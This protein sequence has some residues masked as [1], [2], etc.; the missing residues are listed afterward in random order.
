MQAPDDSPEPIIATATTSATSVGVDFDFDQL[1]VSG[2]GAD[3]D[4]FGIWQPEVTA[5]ARSEPHPPLE[6]EHVFELKAHELLGT[7][8]A[9]RSTLGKASDGGDIGIEL[10][11][12]DIG[13]TGFVT[14]ETS[15]LAGSCRVK[16]AT[17]P[18]GVQP[19]VVGTPLR[20]RANLKRFLELVSMIQVS[21]IEF[22]LRL[23][24]MR[25]TIVI[26]GR[27]MPVPV[28]PP[29]P[30]T[31]GGEG[32]EP[33]R[34]VDGN[35]LSALVSYL[36]IFAERDDIE[37]KFNVV[38]VGSEQSVTGSRGAI[39]RVTCRSSD[40]IPAFSLTP[41]SLEVLC[42]LVPEFQSS[43]VAYSSSASSHGFATDRLWVCIPK[44]SASFP[45]P[46]DT[47][48]TNRTGTMLVPRPSLI[49]AVDRLRGG[50]AGG[51]KIRLPSLAS[52][53]KV[54]HL[55]VMT[56]D[57]DEWTDAVAGAHRNEDL[58]S[59]NGWEG[60][61]DIERLLTILKHFDSANVELSYSG[62]ALIL[63]DESASGILRM[64]SIFGR[65]AADTPAADTKF[66]NVAD[67]GAGAAMAASELDQVPSAASAAHTAL[68]G[69]LDTV[70][71]G[72]V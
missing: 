12:G 3:G 66:E 27:H 28:W 72:L 65:F 20:F 1:V 22:R 4:Q 54:L 43:T 47:L 51:V 70:L 2:H 63:S 26:D 13:A 15:C 68:S 10:F 53:E 57:R 60:L 36:A 64:S 46:A 14:F 55:S 67:N 42:Q 29:Y 44:S 48:L 34:D 25:M 37:D 50:S 17:S 56:R 5:L 32:F 45:V 58:S 62:Q 30:A 11:G 21:E 23:D 71:A 24:R 31:I 6:N 52:G 33:A 40:T 59:A 8:K 61:V 16:L 35:T 39:G 18:F 19:A 69:S 49:Q 41:D 38:N 7:L 9:L